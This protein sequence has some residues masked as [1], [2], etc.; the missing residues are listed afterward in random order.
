MSSWSHVEGVPID[1]ALRRALRD[2]AV[3]I[4]GSSASQRLVCAPFFASYAATR[5][6]ANIVFV[7]LT[8]RKRHFPWLFLARLASD[9]A[10][11]RARKHGVPY[12]G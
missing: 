12:V 7:L 1:C 8:G 4:V 10:L 6:R 2:R 5:S 9:L 3:P 11:L